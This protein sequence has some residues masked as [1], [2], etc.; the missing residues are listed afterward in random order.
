VND[1]G[2]SAE[3]DRRLLEPALQRSPR[4]VLHHTGSKRFRSKRKIIADPH[5][6]ADIFDVASERARGQIQGVIDQESPRRHE[7][8]LPQINGICEAQSIYKVIFVAEKNGFDVGF[9]YFDVA[10]SEAHAGL[11]VLRDF[12]REFEPSTQLKFCIAIEPEGECGQ[13]S[14]ER[15]IRIKEKR[16]FVQNLPF[17]SSL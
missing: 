5:R 10:N 11:V 8:T 13:T 6:S 15:K 12:S 9:D 17:V 1:A 7:G 4:F 16:I 3:C 2:A 14:F